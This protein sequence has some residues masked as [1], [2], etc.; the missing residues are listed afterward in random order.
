MTKAD[1]RLDRL[2]SRPSDFHWDEL[3]TLMGDYNFSW[4]PKAGGS[5]HGHFYNSQTKRK[6]GISKPHNPAILKMYQ[7]KDIL[8]M[9]E[10]D[11]FI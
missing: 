2:R 6:L 10:E 5:S 3:V 1:K 8:K 9:L 11:G 7:I 4:S